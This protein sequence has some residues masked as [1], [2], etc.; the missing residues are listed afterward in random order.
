MGL[1]RPQS[2]THAQ[3]T[4]ADRKRRIADSARM[5][6][7]QSVLVATRRTSSSGCLILS[8]VAASALAGGDTSRVGH[9][10]PRMTLAHRDESQLPRMLDQGT[11]ITMA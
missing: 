5:A 10:H 11:I 1:A 7:V 9:R 6:H 3:A 4:R 8:A 2:V